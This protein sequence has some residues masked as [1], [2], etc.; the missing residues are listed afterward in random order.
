MSSAAPIYSLMNE[1]RA[2]AESA[3]WAQFSSPRDRAEFCASWLTILCAQLEQVF[4]AVV[5][6]NA[7]EGSGYTPAAVWPDASRNM[8]YL[9][10]VA[11]RT[12]KERR[13][14]VAGPQQADK[15]PASDEPAYV[16]Y[17][18]EVGGQLHGAIVLHLP[19]GNEAALQ[20][21]TR[22]LHWASAW[23]IDQFRTQLLVAEQGKRQ[24]LALA[25]EVLATGLQETT[26]GASVTAVVNELATKLRC[27]RVSAGLEHA[28][29]VHV[30]AI[31]HTA[32]FDRKTDVVS[33]IE[34]AMDEVLDLDAALVHPPLGADAID[35]LAHVEL[36]SQSHHPFICSVPLVSG[37]HSIGVLTLERADASPFDADTVQ[38]CKTMGLL[39]GPVFEMKRVAEMS[40]WQRLRATAHDG[41]AA[42]FGPRHPGLK[43]TA[44]VAGVAIVLMSVLNGHYQ[45]TAKTVIEGAVQRAAAA[46]FEGFIAESFVRAGDKVRKGQILARI[47]DRTLMLEQAKWHA[48][49][50]QAQ[51]RLRQA[52]AANDRTNM[53][54]TSAQVD[55]AEAQLALVEE[56]I[57]RAKL[58][59][60]FDGIV[61]SGDLSQQLGSPVET[62]KVLFEIAPLDAYRVI[63]NVDERDIVS[64]QVGQKG[65]IALSGLPY[66][67]IPMTVSQ[68]TPVSTAQDG[69]NFFRVEATIA[70]APPQLRPGMEGVG[71]V[72]A[73]QRRLIWIWTH[74]LVDW[75]RLWLWRWTS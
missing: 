25:T 73:G 46:P 29:E 65:E 62:G 58:T 10:P 40:A 9:A 6:L 1:A 36:A 38:L 21:A 35:A 20:R 66:K 54:I 42:L 16:G 53:G 4:G 11:E 3:A 23:L 19:P 68:V 74:S 45:V 33:L 8:Q 63:L 47:D 12:L 17:P 34:D 59:A 64:V 69:H 51:K 60:P 55:Q 75:T 49:V 24:R 28:G 52:A 56:K 39:L 15:L 71:K 30:H 43:L 48:E 32:T 13:G 22:L 5:L 31:S 27:E 37:G 70:G 7:E 44:V 50:A 61:V 41:A 57:A 26:L 14:V 2:R 67:T 72:D 18:I